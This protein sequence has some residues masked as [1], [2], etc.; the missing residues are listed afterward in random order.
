MRL[1]ADA[2]NVLALNMGRIAVDIDGIEMS[3][4]LPAVNQNGCTLQ[5]T[6]ALGHITVENPLPPFTALPGICC[7][8][9][10]ITAEDNSLLYALSHRISILASLNGSI[11]RDP[12]IFCVWGRGRF[13]Y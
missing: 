10:H 4:L 6:D 11:I 13:R 12:A 8:T 7:S 9:S 5:I 2:I 3:E 1:L